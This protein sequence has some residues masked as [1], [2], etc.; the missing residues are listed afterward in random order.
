MQCQRVLI[1]TGSLCFGGAERQSVA[2]ANGLAG[3]GIEV[4]FGYAAQVHQLRDLLVPAV[5][6]RTY[7]LEKSGRLD[8]RIFYRLRRLLARLRPDVVICVNPYPL[9]LVCIARLGL[10]WRG[11]RLVTVLH[12]TRLNKGIET[13]MVSRILAWVI[14]RPYVTAIFVSHAQLAHWRRY[15]GVRAA[16]ARVIYNGID[17][18]Y[19]R[20]MSLARATRDRMVIAICAGLRPVKRHLDF[21]AAIGELVEAGISV[22]ALLIGDGP[23][24]ARIEAYCRDRGLAERCEITGFQ[25]DVR[26]WLA[27]AD[28]CALCSSSETFPMSLL[29]AM[30]MGVPVVAPA[31]GGIPEL[32]DDG[33]SGLLFD[34]G[35]PGTLTDAFRRLLSSGSQNMRAMGEAGRDVVTKRFSESRMVVEYRAVLE[36]IGPL[37]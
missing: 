6:E 36:S 18:D 7:C 30:S 16:Q 37:P 14:N 8:L 34:S 22:R 13:F 24:R 33:V 2:L 31:I 12:S 15:Y 29:E 19:F 1:I 25:A 21:L 10:L 23:E 26:P 17:P 28:I 4:S 3:A 32:V 35:C 20:P 11:P 27:K 5:R 9:F